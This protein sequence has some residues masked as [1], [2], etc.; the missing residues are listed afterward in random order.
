MRKLEV[1][2]DKTIYVG[3]LDIF[4]TC[5][6]EFHH[7]WHRCFAK[8]VKLLLCT[9]IRIVSL[10]YRVRLDIMNDIINVYDIMKHE[11][12]RLDSNHYV[13]DNANCIPLTNKK[14]S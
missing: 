13:V 9:L 7:E 11:I 2:F 10:L 6:Y 14:F 3:I 1:K 4:K 5:L 12:N 8:I